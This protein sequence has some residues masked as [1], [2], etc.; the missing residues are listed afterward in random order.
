MKK[1]I[2]IAL[3]IAFNSA[4]FAQKAYLAEVGSLAPIENFKPD[5]PC[6]IVVNL[7]L[8][9]NEFGI[10]EIAKTEDMYLWTWSPFEFVLPHPKANGE[11]DPA[12]KNSNP[13]LKMTK[14]GDGIYSYV[15]TPTEFYEVTPQQVYD[16]DFKLLLKPKDGGGF[17]SA[18]F[19]TEDLS[20]EVDLPVTVVKLASFPEGV[21]SKKDTLLF[22]DGDP[23][24]IIYDHKVETK[25]SLD[26]AT[27]F[28]IFPKAKGSDGLDYKLA[29]N[30]KQVV[31]F[32]QLKMS[33]GTN[34]VFTGTFIPEQ[35]FS[36]PAGVKI[37]EMTLQI[38]R[39][40]LVNSDDAVDEILKYTFKDST[41]D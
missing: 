20:I 16:R 12:W 33:V 10:V 3:L 15:L 34:D 14:E 32:P 24:S 5:K 31:N 23:F 26:S 18:D 7:N 11:V 37:T 40:N 35:I 4:A 1:R 2:L 38:V 8:T 29:A 25:P 36:V 19:K 41:C 21:G 39:P 9:K 6:K 28:Y 30:A 13:L 27:E 17:G 22:G